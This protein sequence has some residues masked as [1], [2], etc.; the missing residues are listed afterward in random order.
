MAMTLNQQNFDEVLAAGQP[1]LV[2][3]WAVWCGPC[4]MMA[5]IVDELAEEFEGVVTVGKVDVDENPDLAGR[6]GVMSIPTLLLFRDGEVLATSVGVKP[7]E[8]LEE[9]LA[10]YGL[11]PGS[12]EL[13]AAE[14][15][16]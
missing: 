2:D 16:E 13:E 5:P 11:V 8:Q 14:I 9:L 4:T 12:G 6:Y 10:E 15:D 7:K 3:F 1:V